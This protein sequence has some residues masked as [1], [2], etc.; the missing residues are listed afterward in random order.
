MI[1]DGRQQRHFGPSNF[2]R[3]RPYDRTAKTAV[4]GKTKKTWDIRGVAAPWVN[5][6]RGGGSVPKPPQPKTEESGGQRPPS[7]NRKNLKLPKLR[8]VPTLLLFRAKRGETSL[9]FRAKRGEF[10]FGVFPKIKK[11]RETHENP[12]LQLRQERRRR[13]KEG[14]SETRHKSS[15]PTHGGW[16]KIRKKSISPCNF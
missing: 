6:P 14:G 4:Q 15:N 1:T 7:Q 16:G 5:H 13:G 2:D 8:V 3:F 10:F 11:R 12:E 9:P